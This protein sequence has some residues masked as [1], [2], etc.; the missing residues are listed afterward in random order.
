MLL[1]SN[2]KGHSSAREFASILRA[3]W[4]ERIRLFFRRCG[5]DG[6]LLI[7]VIRPIFSEIDAAYDTISLVIVKG[8]L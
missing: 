6:R 4:I 7:A 3:E 2:Q 8:G 1:S 5:F